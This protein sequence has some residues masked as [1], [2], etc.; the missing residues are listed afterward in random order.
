MSRNNLLTSKDVRAELRDML[1][2]AGSQASLARQLGI[3]PTHMGDLLDGTR[4]PG[5]K[6]LP[7]LGLK[8]VILYAPITRGGSR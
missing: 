6:V 1:K 2:D 8:K 4:E 3:T 7:A 5:A